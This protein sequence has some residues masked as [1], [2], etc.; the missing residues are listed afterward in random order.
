[1]AAGERVRRVSDAG[2]N[3]SVASDDGVAFRG[4]LS[5]ADDGAFDGVG[6]LFADPPAAAGVGDVP[7]A[8]VRL[9]F[10][11]RWR[12]SADVRSQCA[13][14]LDLRCDFATEADAPTDSLMRMPFAVVVF[15][16]APV[17]D[18]RLSMP[19]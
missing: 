1:M 7:S 13:D 4:A 18:G 6:T 5:V 15:F 12:V 17:F 16:V 14:S 3:V 9:V 19:P 11:D 2:F 8:L 10:C